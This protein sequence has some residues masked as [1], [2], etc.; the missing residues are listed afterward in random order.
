[1]LHKWLNYCS[2]LFYQPDSKYHRRLHKEAG[3]LVRS[4][5]KGVIRSMS[6]ASWPRR[7]RDVG[8]VHVKYGARMCTRQSRAWTKRTD[9]Y[10]SRRGCWWNRMW[11]PKELS[12]YRLRWHSLG[13]EAFISHLLLFI[14]DHSPW[15]YWFNRLIWIQ[16]KLATWTDNFSSKR[17]MWEGRKRRWAMTNDMYVLAY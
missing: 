2:V 8:G 1:M 14:R 15:T 4:K 17:N 9:L 10:S 11:T 3:T 12:S 13:K 5:D 16:L 7:S 6:N